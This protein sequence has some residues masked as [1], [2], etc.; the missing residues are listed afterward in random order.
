MRQI[1]K[2]IEWGLLILLTLFS[3]LIVLP[4]SDMFD[5]NKT[6]AHAKETGIYY[7]VK[8]PSQTYFNQEIEIEGII[9]DGHN[10]VVMMKSKN[11]IGPN[12]LPNWVKV[13]TDQGELLRPGSGGSSNNLL[14]SRG[15]VEYK[16]VPSDIKQITIHKNAFGESFSFKVDLSGGGLNE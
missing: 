1:V 11:F 6:I 13:T 2:V 7:E 4:F 3:I 14:R 12:Q 15:Y 9:Y 16:N 5:F 10:L 8:Q